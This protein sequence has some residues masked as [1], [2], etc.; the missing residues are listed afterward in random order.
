MYEYLNASL[1]QV[2][3]AERGLKDTNKLTNVI[4][5]SHL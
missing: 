2:K 4:H 1:N 3:K 5:E